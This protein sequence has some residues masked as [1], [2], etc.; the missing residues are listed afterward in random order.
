MLKIT[1]QNYKNYTY[2]LTKYNYLE[3]STLTIMYKKNQVKDIIFYTKAFQN[4]IKNTV[5][6][7]IL[8]LIDLCKV[9]NYNYNFWQTFKLIFINYNQ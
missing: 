5:N 7:I 2:V 4:L 6:W 1:Q 8:F 9:I 3:F